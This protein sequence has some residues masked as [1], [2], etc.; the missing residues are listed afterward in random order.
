[1]SFELNI[2]A[3][4]RKTRKPLKRGRRKIM[5]TNHNAPVMPTDFAQA[6]KALAAE[7]DFEDQDMSDWPQVSYPAEEEVDPRKGVKVNYVGEPVLT[8]GD[9]GEQVQSGWY[10]DDQI[11]VWD[12]TFGWRQWGPFDIKDWRLDEPVLCF[13]KNGFAYFG[14][15]PISLQWGDDWNDSPYEYNAGLPYKPFMKVAY[16][17]RF[18]EP[19]EPWLGG[20]SPYSVE[21]INKGEAPWLKYEAW[22]KEDE[23]E[24]FAGATLKEFIEFVQEC[25]GTVYLPHNK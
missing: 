11:Y 3:A 19:N 5:T 13:V 20:N 15:A 14:Y 23:R 22:E 25:G 6:I 17:H 7:F 10:Y 1:V 16:D 12:A 9:F 24:L 18:S 21:E 4:A 8:R 2:V